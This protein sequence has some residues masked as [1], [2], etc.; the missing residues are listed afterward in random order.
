MVESFKR[1]LCLVF[2][3]PLGNELVGLFYPVPVVVSVH[4]VVA[5]DYGGYLGCACLLALVF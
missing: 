5:T 2:C 1:C 3:F 4:G